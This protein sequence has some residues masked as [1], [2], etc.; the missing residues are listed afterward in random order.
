M[1]H[2]TNSKIVTK[3]AFF[4]NESGTAIIE[5]A[6]IAPVFFLIFF[7]LF[8]FGLFMFHKVVLENI[9]VEVSR[10][11]SLGGKSSPACLG[12]V[13][14]EDFIKCV[15]T[16]KAQVLINPSQVQVQ[17]V[18]ATAP[19]KS[20]SPDIC[21]DDPNNPSSTVLACTQYQELNGTAGYQGI[22]DSD[23]GLKSDIVEVRITYP[24][25]VQ[26]PLLNEYFSAPVYNS[27]TGVT[28]TQKGYLSITA[29]TVI[30]N[31]PF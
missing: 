15:V 13:T 25:K 22:A 17:V 8:E 5:F 23:A 9:A 31:E 20:T 2:C 3:T 4:S 14:R 1:K 7:G 21:L 28:T 10:I 29:V 26:L 12:K 27:V 19:N 16:D 11:V 18:K 6:I 24:W 30:K